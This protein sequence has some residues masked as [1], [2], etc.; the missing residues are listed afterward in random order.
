MCRN[1]AHIQHMPF[2][3]ATGGEREN[4]CMLRIDV[5]VFILDSCLELFFC[6]RQVI[7]GLQHNKN[8]R[9]MKIRF[10]IVTMRVWV[11]LE[12]NWMDECGNPSLALSP[13][14]F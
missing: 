3:K 8:H 10:G 5:L 7:Q 2:E 4:D 12:E 1:P 11:T 6:V 9:L 14:Q 13:S